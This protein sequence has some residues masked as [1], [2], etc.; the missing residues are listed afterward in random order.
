[1]ELSER[2]LAAIAAQRA[3]VRP[4]ALRAAE[5]A[6]LAVIQTAVHPDAPIRPEV[7]AVVARYAAILV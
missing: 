1:V 4:A 7:E 3:A 2:L 5:Q 6:V